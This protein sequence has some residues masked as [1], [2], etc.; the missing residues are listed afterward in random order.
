VLVVWL[1][2]SA[3]WFGSVIRLRG[4]ASRE[5]FSFVTWL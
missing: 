3:W 4:Q 1:R 2:G 5:R